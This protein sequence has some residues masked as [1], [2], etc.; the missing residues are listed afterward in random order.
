MRFVLDCG[1]NAAAFSVERRPPWGAG[2]ATARPAGGGGAAPRSTRTQGGALLPRSKGSPGQRAELLDAAQDAGA[3]HEAD[4]PEVLYV[5]RRISIE[6][7]EIGVFAFLDRAGH[8]VEA[9][10]AR[11]DG[12]R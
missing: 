7:K 12:G 5:A 6:Q 10:G 4:A 1:S 11:C 2:F 9:R 3:H 8:V